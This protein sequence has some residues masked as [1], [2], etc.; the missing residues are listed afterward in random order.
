MSNKINIDDFHSK[1]C[2]ERYLYAMTLAKKINYYFDQNCFIY[3]ADDKLLT[4][5]FTFYDQSSNK[6]NLSYK[7]SYYCFSLF[8]HYDYTCNLW[9]HNNDGY[10]EKDIEYYFKSFKIVSQDGEIIKLKL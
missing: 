3:D 6:P 4:E 5:K 9:L 1:Q 10:S 8:I 7:A 2:Y